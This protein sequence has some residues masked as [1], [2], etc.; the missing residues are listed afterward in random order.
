MGEFKIDHK[1]VIWR[2]G[3]LKSDRLLVSGYLHGEVLVFICDTHRSGH[4]GMQKTKTKLRARESIGG[5]W[6]I[7]LGVV[8]LTFDTCCRSKR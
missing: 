1:G 4:R 2:E 7:L 6:G 3:L 8:V 5:G